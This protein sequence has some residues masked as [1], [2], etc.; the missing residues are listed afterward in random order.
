MSQFTNEP[1]KDEDLSIFQSVGIDIKGIE[2][3]QTD[4]SQETP[5]IGPPPSPAGDSSSGNTSL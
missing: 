4:L 2:G 3:K 5:M 1:P